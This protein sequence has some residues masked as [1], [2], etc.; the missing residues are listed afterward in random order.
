MAGT[1]PTTDDDVDP[2][3]AA[4]EALSDGAEPAALDPDIAAF[5]ALDAEPGT[6]GD[7]T[8]ANGSRAEQ[9]KV[10]TEPQP[11]LD[12]FQRFGKW[13]REGLDSDLAVGFA[14][15]LGQGVGARAGEWWGNREADLEFGRMPE[16][17]VYKGGGLIDNLPKEGP[18]QWARGAGRLV[19][20]IPAAVLAGGGAGTQAALGAGLGLTNA[21]SGGED[22]A[23]AMALGAGGGLIGGKLGQIPG[24]ALRGLT[25][26]ATQAAAEV[27]E[28]AGQ[29]P[30]AMA[31][32][33]WLQAPARK[34]AQL[35]NE[36]AD[37]ILRGAQ[38]FGSYA[39]D[40]ASG[41]TGAIDELFNAGAPVAGARAVSPIPLPA[42]QTGGQ[43][44]SGGA[45]YGAPAAGRAPL[46]KLLEYAGMSRGELMGDAARAL[47]GMV[48]KA[49]GSLD[50]AIGGGLGG[51]LGQAG[52]MSGGGPAKAKAQDVAYAG[53]PTTSWAVQSV[54]SSGTSGLSPEDEQRLTE[55]VM[56][57]DEQKMIS[58]NFLLAQRNPAYAKRMQDEYESLQHGGE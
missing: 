29:V 13:A 44:L 7:K 26:P 20:G 23:T 2:D 38:Q 49:A 31:E 58:T 39:D 51:G 11:E 46:E 41:M 45:Q 21:Y 36:S 14:E 15:G 56:S 22:I 30:Q 19:T 37:P 16:G 28:W 57:G 47:P 33:P 18:A 43:I 40:A 6:G 9:E 12:A 25:R 24:N 3:I 53:T 34:L 1:P 52:A 32:G 54:L 42:A 4:F 35:A 55:A 5:E 27:G 10:Q 50:R 17:T 48:T 8:P